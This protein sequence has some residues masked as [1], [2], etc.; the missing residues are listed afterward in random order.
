[1][2]FGDFQCPPCGRV[3]KDLKEIEKDYGSRLRVIFHQFPL[4]MH[5]HAREAAFASEAADRQH[6]FWEM[7][8]MLYQEQETWSKAADVPA[9]FR[10]YAGKIGL[11]LERFEKDIKDPEVAAKVD[12][13]QKVGLARGVASTPTLFINK[14]LVPATSLNSTAVRQAIDEALKEKPKP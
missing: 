4:D 5:A 14:T 7:H 1:L 13:D 10:E 8:D 9:L 3:A 2:E 6:R 11:D 12:A